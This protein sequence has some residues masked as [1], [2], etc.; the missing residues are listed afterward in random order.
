MISFLKLF[1]QV[2]AY[3]QVVWH[4]ILSEEEDLWYGAV[5]AIYTLLA[6]LVAFLF[7]LLRLNWKIFGEGIFSLASFAQMGVLLGCALTNEI[8]V[9]YVGYILFAIIYHSSITIA[10]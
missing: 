8:I 3:I 2:L 5:E 6:A 10:R 1:L 7:G 4:D 9:G